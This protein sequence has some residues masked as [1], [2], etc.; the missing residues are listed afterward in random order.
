M[1][2]FLPMFVSLPSKILANDKLYAF[3]QQ[4]PTVSQKTT[5]CT[6]QMISLRVNESQT[7][8]PLTPSKEESKLRLASF[9]MEIFLPFAFRIVTITSSLRKLTCQSFPFGLTRFF[10]RE[11]DSRSRGKNFFS[12]GR[13]KKLFAQITLDRASKLL[14]HTPCQKGKNPSLWELHLYGSQEKKI[15]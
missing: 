3:G 13:S 10:L 4:K 8:D 6:F 11:R 5:P 15:N 2:F 1:V 7:Q 14:F 12:E 9:F